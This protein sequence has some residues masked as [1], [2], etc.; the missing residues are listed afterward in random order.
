MD[1]WKLFCEEMNVPSLLT[2]EALPGFDRLQS[3]LDHAKEFAYERD[4]LLCWMNAGRPSGRPELTTVP[5][6]ASTVAAAL[7]E[8]YRERARWWGG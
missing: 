7:K 1:G 5:L 6:T 4:E 3:R 8:V 2:S